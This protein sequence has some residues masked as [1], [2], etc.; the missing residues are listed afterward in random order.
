MLE[1]AWK[2][3]VRHHPE[4]ERRGFHVLRHAFNTR[5]HDV[6]DNPLIAMR[7]EG[8]RSAVERWVPANGD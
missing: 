6:I 2:L 5:M 8:S 1:D 7:A 3:F 4:H